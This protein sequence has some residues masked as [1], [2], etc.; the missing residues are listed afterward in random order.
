MKRGERMGRAAWGGKTVTF[1]EI[2]GRLTARD[3][4]AKDW[5]S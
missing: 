3:L 5:K 4:G 1:D 2:D